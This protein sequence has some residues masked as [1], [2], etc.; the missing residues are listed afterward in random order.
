MRR[1]LTTE[2]QTLQ[3]KILADFEPPTYVLHG[4]ATEETIQWF[5][6]TRGAVM[7][8][9]LVKTLQEFPSLVPEAFRADFETIN[10]LE[11]QMRYVDF[12]QS[13]TTIDSSNI[14]SW[15]LSNIV[16]FESMRPNKD[17]SAERNM[18]IDDFPLCNFSDDVDSATREQAI[19]FVKKYHTVIRDQYHF[20]AVNVT[21]G[22][23]HIA[24]ADTS[25][26]FDD[27]DKRRSQDIASYEPFKCDES[28]KWDYAFVGLEEM[29]HH[30]DTLIDCYPDPTSL[31]K[32]DIRQQQLKAVISARKKHPDDEIRADAQDNYQQNL[33]Y[34]KEDGSSHNI[35]Q[36]DAIRSR[37]GLL[38]QE[39]E[40]GRVEDAIDLLR[41]LE[42]D[43]TRVPTP[44]GESRL[45]D[46]YHPVY[47][48][49]ETWSMMLGVIAKHAQ[50]QTTSDSKLGATKVVRANTSEKTR[51]M[52]TILKEANAREKETKN[53]HDSPPDWSPE[54]RQAIISAAPDYISSATGGSAL[55]YLKEENRTTEGKKLL[56]G[57]GVKELYTNMLTSQP[58]ERPAEITDCY[59]DHLLALL[60]SKTELP[61]KVLMMIWLDRYNPNLARDVMFT[62]GSGRDEKIGCFGPTGKKC[63]DTEVNSKLWEKLTGHMALPE[64]YQIRI[65]ATN[66]ELPITR[67]YG[68]YHD[69]IIAFKEEATGLFDQYQAQVGSTEENA[70][71]IAEQRTAIAELAI[72]QDVPP[73]DIEEKT[74]VEDDMPAPASPR[75]TQAVPPADADAEETKECGDSTEIDELKKWANKIIIDAKHPK[76]DLMKSAIASSTD[77]A[78]TKAAIKAIVRLVHRKHGMFNLSG[79]Y[80]NE[81]NEGLQ[82][83]K[84]ETGANG[85]FEFLA[86]YINDY[87]SD[88]S[89]RGMTGITTHNDQVISKDEAEEHIGPRC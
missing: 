57:G 71:F 88:Y 81:N 59:A 61:S 38:E 7:L 55:Y 41:A 87:D 14:E 10:L 77:L 70:S 2:Q 21:D 89:S 26:G 52:R 78:S 22:D 64:E 46:V 6:A 33:R 67:C 86:N 12:V 5:G 31:A 60:D 19:S 75:W 20:I 8:E 29:I 69:A 9:R 40:H 34:A 16:A 4:S 72:P 39:Q 45:K 11:L 73:G 1:E 37:L 48:A 80:L 17:E 25:K 36:T 83:A 62:F 84:K 85:R 35:R 27:E 49:Q 68:K 50:E 56:E 23:I 42:C 51:P 65:Q 28:P 44:W 18:S 63:D 58:V 32:R 24:E 76:S 54:A 43:E 74:C 79:R 15:L 13:P 53:Y 3:A 47:S 82:S 66:I 30:I